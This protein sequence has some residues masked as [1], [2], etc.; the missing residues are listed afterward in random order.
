MLS[1]SSCL[2]SWSE[3]PFSKDNAAVTEHTFFFL[4]ISLYDSEFYLL[5]YSRMSKKLCLRF[6]PQRQNIRASKTLDFPDPLG[7]IMLVNPRKGPAKVSSSK[8]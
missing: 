1:G 7:P 5:I 2:L 3:R 6:S 4:L 8:I